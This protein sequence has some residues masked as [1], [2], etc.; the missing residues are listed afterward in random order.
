MKLNDRS[1]ISYLKRKIVTK[2]HVKIQDDFFILTRNM[3][4]DF[5]DFK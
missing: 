1:D 3:K 2:D 5:R 4:I